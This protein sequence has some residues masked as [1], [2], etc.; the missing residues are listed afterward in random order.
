M[1]SALVSTSGGLENLEARLE[2][3][4]E[5]AGVASPTLPAVLAVLG[6]RCRGR[7]A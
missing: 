2:A 3:Y 1:R 5:L 7:G 4:P 6:G